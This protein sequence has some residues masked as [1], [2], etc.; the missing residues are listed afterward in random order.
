MQLFQTIQMQQLWSFKS[1]CIYTEKQ[2]AT[3]L[4]S[5]K[6]YFFLPQTR[7]LGVVELAALDSRVPG[8]CIRAVGFSAG[9]H[10]KG[11]LPSLLM[12]WPLLVHQRHL[13]V[14]TTCSPLQA[15]SRWGTRLPLKRGSE[16]VRGYPIKKAHYKLSPGAKHRCFCHIISSKSLV[17][18]HSSYVM[19]FRVTAYCDTGQ[20]RIATI[21]NCIK[22]ITHAISPFDI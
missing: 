3:K 5:W 4:I 7:N 17:I 18:S 11:L 8:G 9:S 10:R 15:A 12:A 14:L 1:S 19:C 13:S 6:Q 2:I 22:P 21:R 20:L 16:C